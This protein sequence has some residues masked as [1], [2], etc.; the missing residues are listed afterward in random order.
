MV[1]GRLDRAGVTAAVGVLGEGSHLPPL[2]RRNGVTG[3]YCRTPQ[4]PPSAPTHLAVGQADDP[5]TPVQVLAAEACVEGQGELLPLPPDPP[6]LPHVGSSRKM[7]VS[8]A[9][10]HTK[11]SKSTRS[12]LSR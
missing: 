8:W 1:L 10:Q 3:R 11:R 4:L 12:R 2:G 6:P 7:Q 9:A 5:F